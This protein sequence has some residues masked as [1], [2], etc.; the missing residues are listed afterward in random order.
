M[1]YFYDYLTLWLL[2]IVSRLNP[3]IF[4]SINTNGFIKIKSLLKK[5]EIK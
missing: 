1:L 2:S 4:K 3:D 5:P